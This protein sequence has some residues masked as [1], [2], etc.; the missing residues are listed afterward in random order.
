MSKQKPFVSRASSVQE[1]L[2]AVAKL[3]RVLTTAIQQWGQVEIVIQK[4]EPRRSLDQNALQ[5]KWCQE[6]SQQ[7]DQTAD[8]YQAWCK[9][10]IGM[11]ILCRDSKKY[12]DACRQVL[13]DLTYEQ[14]LA[15]M[16]HPFDWPVTRAM[17]K[18]QKA[19]YLDR[20]WQ[21]FTG[22]GMRLTDPNLRGF[23]PDEYKEVKNA[24]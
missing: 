12:A 3:P 8:E 10:H 19:E 11:V 6:A 14:K 4:H 18:K 17:N 2:A 5:W 13:G 22:L 16:R 9:L 20:V 23:C 15:L 21:H 7:G 1:A 24:A